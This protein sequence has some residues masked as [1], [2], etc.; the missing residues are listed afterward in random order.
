MSRLGF[1]Q[2]R[3]SNRIASDTTRGPYIRDPDPVSFKA[4]P[5]PAATTFNATHSGLLTHAAEKQQ[6]S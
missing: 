3:Q 2:V 4:P 6:I 5:E 1:H